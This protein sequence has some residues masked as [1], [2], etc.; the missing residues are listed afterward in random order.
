MIKRAYPELLQN[1]EADTDTVS[2]DLGEHA[3]LKE[4]GMDMSMHNPSNNRVKEWWLYIHATL[5]QC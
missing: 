2:L 5:S 3:F 4:Q 1:S